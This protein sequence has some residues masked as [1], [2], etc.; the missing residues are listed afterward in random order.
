MKFKIHLNIFNKYAT[1][2]I[3]KEGKGCVNYDNGRIY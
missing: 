3:Q 1:I 2:K